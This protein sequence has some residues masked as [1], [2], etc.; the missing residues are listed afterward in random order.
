MK[1]LG[2][3][4]D[5]HAGGVDLQFPHHENEI[6][7]SEAATGISF[8]NYWMHNGHVQINNEKMSK[9]L[10]N[11][12]TIRQMLALDS[13]AN[14]MGEVIRF[15]ILGSHYRSPFSFSE[16]LLKTALSSLTRLYLVLD[17][18]GVSSTKNDVWEKTEHWKSFNSAMADDFNTPDAISVLFGLAR[19]SNRMMD[20]GQLDVARDLC[21]QLTNLA[22]VLGLLYQ[23]PQVFLKGLDNTEELPRSLSSEWIEQLINQR[24]TAREQGDWKQA[25]EIR[26]DL[27]DKGIILE[28]RSDGTTSWRLERIYTRE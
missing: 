19:E 14:R 3:N 4:F 26:I 28:D 2:K 18:V 15:M 25:D 16:T 1:C 11:F 22:G 27:S 8:V 7:Q 10:G 23:K 5:I 20:A 9:S 21:G 13:S 17:K 12:F 6:A 24:S